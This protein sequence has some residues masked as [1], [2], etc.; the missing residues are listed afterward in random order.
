MM[1]AANWSLFF[2][3]I[4]AYVCTRRIDDL[5]ITSRWMRFL[6][7]EAESAAKAIRA[8]AAKPGER[9]ARRPDS[10]GSEPVYRLSAA[11][12]RFGAAEHHCLRQSKLK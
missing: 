1:M 3:T 10:G 9:W 11:G 8:T 4:G 2:Q 6:V 12:V 7:A 5:N